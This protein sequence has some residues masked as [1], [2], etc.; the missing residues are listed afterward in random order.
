VRRLKPGELAIDFEDPGYRPGT[1]GYKLERLIQKIMV[2]LRKYMKPELF[3]DLLRQLAG[4]CQHEQD[5]D[6]FIQALL[7]DREAFTKV[8]ADVAK[9]ILEPLE[10]FVVR[11]S[12]NILCA[13]L[14]HDGSDF[15]QEVVRTVHDALRIYFE[16]KD[17]LRPFDPNNPLPLLQRLRARRSERWS[18][19]PSVPVTKDAAQIRQAD[20][21]YFVHQVIP[22]VGHLVFPHSNLIN[23]LL[24]ALT[25]TGTE[26]KQ[27]VGARSTHVYYAELGFE[28]VDHI[29]AHIV[30]ERIVDILNTQLK[31]EVLND[32]IIQWVEERWRSSYEVTKDIR[33]QREMQRVWHEYERRKR[34]VIGKRPRR[35]YLRARVAIRMAID[36]WVPELFPGVQG[37]VLSAVLQLHEMMQCTP[38]V[39]SIL[40][41]SIDSTLDHLMMVPKQPAADLN[42]P[43][44]KLVRSYGAEGPFSEDC[45]HEM[46]RACLYLFHV[47]ADHPVDARSYAESATVIFAKTLT[48]LKEGKV[49]EIIQDRLEDQWNEKWE[50]S[51]PGILAYLMDQVQMWISDSE[52][53]LDKFLRDAPG[54]IVIPF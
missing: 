23:E 42:K 49:I 2:K 5:T 48:W 26:W 10:R 46:A 47:G 35:L 8:A 17:K 34:A 4:S 11:I 3:A 15:V 39:K 9:L 16:E 6:C 53:G 25:S 40:Y 32:L 21:D 29:M 30:S 44:S 24:R 43:I 54:V 33:K 52:E 45:L 22:K 50:I 13:I 19:H 14:A 18:L 28:G 51:F 12:E 38:V 1:L 27:A 7:N 41:H 37:L 36:L 20:M 31:P